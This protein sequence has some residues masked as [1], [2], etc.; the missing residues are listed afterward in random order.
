MSSACQGGIVTEMRQKCGRNAAEFGHGGH[1][2]PVAWCGPHAA[3]YSTPS[4]RLPAA[5]PLHHAQR[6]CPTRGFCDCVR[7][8]FH[9]VLRSA[10]PFL[11]TSAACKTMHPLSISMLYASRLYQLCLSPST[12]SILLFSFFFSLVASIS[13]RFLLKLVLFIVSSRRS[14][15]TRGPTKLPSEAGPAATVVATVSTINPIADY[16][17]RPPSRPSA[18]PSS[19]SSSS[20]HRP[21]RHLDLVG[22]IVIGAENRAQAAN[23]SRNSGTE[24]SAIHG[25]HR[26]QGGA[27]RQAARQGA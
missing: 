20:S 15:R 22:V 12:A 4:T 19:S 14:R 16:R 10:P 26:L 21:H 3:F 1:R 17:A 7:A 25:R 13:C 24:I 23:A 27:S 8:K 6:L 11:I 5:L 2:W 18:S 9:A